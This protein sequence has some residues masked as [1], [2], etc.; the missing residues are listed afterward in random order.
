M[1]AAAAR[2]WP[3]YLMEAA[4]LAVFMISACFVVAA[5]EHPASAALQFLP[6]STGRRVFTGIAMG[7]TAIAIIYSPWGRRSG[8]HFNPSVTLTFWRLGRVSTTDAVFYVGAQFVGGVVG[9]LLS[10]AVLGESIAHPAVNYVATLPGNSGPGIAFVAELCIS[11]L[12]MS[13]V[14]IVSSRPGLEGYVGLFCGVLVAL[15]IS[16]EAPLS[17]MSMN[18]A[19]SF[20]PALVSGMWNGM[21]IYFVAPP[22]GMLLAAEVHLLR[23]TGADGCAKLYH[24]ESVRCIF[25]QPTLS[26]FPWAKEQSS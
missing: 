3:E 7:L 21:W 10:A 19:R 8:A 24:A 25:C 11:F 6:D 16:I 13:M 1:A 22:L 23:R 15:Y 5:L 17:G 18:P 26:G 4:E 9:V 20:G 12:L 14:L 2:H